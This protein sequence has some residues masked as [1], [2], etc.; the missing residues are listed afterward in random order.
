M[1]HQATR[2]H[3][4]AWIMARIAEASEAG[5]A[6]TK[7]EIIAKACLHFGA[8]ERYVKEILK[9]LEYGK[10]II[11]EFGDVLTKQWHDAL[12]IREKE[13]LDGDKILE[14]LEHEN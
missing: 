13:D 6:L 9:H 14:K 3:K 11:I 12:K 2:I 1:T 4:I 8:G 10:K 7:D 5:K